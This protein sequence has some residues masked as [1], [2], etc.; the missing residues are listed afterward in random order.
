MLTQRLLKDILF[1]SPTPRIRSGTFTAVEV[2][3]VIPDF[4]RHVPTP[5]MKDEDWIVIMLA[6]ATGAGKC[7]RSLHSPFLF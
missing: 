4:M 5:D 3:N 6:G 1:L 2:K 7:T